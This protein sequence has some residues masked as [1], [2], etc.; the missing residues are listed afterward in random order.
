MTPK[1]DAAL[2]QFDARAQAA[3]LARV[4]IVLVHTSLPANIGAAA[5]AMLTM[6]LSQLRLVAPAHFPH[7]DA[8]ALA[9]GAAAL[10]D[11]ARVVATLDEALAGTRLAIESTSRFWDGP[12]RF[13]ALRR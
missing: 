3:T 12:R 10:L 11:R 4:R 9:A 8:T 2:P 1:S 6:G 13:S 5:R 7:A